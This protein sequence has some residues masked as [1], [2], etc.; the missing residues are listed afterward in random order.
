MRDE[1]VAIIEDRA[2]VMPRSG[3]SPWQL[4]VV[5]DDETVHRATRFALDDF[6]FE[7]RPLEITSAYSAHQARQIIADKTD[8]AVVLLDVVME[9][10]YVGLEFVRWVRDELSNPLVRIVMRTGQPGFAPELQVIRDYDIND[11]KDKSGLTNTKLVTTIYAALR[12]FRDI[13][14]LAEQSDELRDAMVAVE[15]ANMAK[16][17]FISHM[18]HEF[19]TPLN[20]IIGLSEMIATEALGPVGTAKYLE[21]AWD[22]ATSGRKLQSMVESVLEIADEETP[23]DLSFFDI[24]ALI[25]AFVEARATVSGEPQSH[26]DAGA[27]LV[28]RAD[29]ENVRAMLTN[30]VNNAVSHN[31]RDCKVRITA[32]LRGDGGV[33]VTVI[34]DGY[35]IP[36]EV[37]D[38]LG[39]PFN[40]TTSP[41]LAGTAGMGLGLMQ[42]RRMIERHNGT[43]SIETD[44]GRG[45]T[46]RLNFPADDAH[47]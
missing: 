35:G 18:S 6:S 26:R 22:I 41:F 5:D 28:I 17:S 24:R 11:Y 45:S 46:V 23:L 36:Q 8:V 25:E 38:R 4:L 20:G 15:Q 14:R 39:Q 42:T 27:G 9:T 29:R 44:I 34:D 33:V 16:M 10:E 1:Q 40:L 47:G 43:M 30:L 31:A 13:V 12:A 7:G 32:G 2:S 21:Y 19:R 3:L 37:I